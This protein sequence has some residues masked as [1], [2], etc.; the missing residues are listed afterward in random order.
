MIQV[1][2]R[3]GTRWNVRD[4]ERQWCPRC[5][6]AL[7][8]AQASEQW[9]TLSA[10]PRP[11]QP[12]SHPR[13]GGRLA[14]GYRW[15]AVR[16]GAG[17]PPRR[18]RLPLGPTPR[19]P[20]IPRWGLVD[21]A[22][23]I[24]PEAAPP[25][26]G[27]SLRAIRATL[28]TTVV[29]LGLA[30]LLHIARYAVLIINRQVLLNSVVAGLATWLPVAASVGAMFAIVGWAFV[31]TEWL[32]SRRASAFGHRNAADPRPVWAL[33]AGCLVPLANVVWA[34]TYLVE[35]ATVE[36][37]YP[38]LRRLIWAWSLLFA[39]STLV[40]VYATATSFPSDTQGIA[41]NTVSFV[42]AYL[43]AMAATVVT[44][45]L[46]FAFEGRPVERPAHR[47]V[48]VADEKESRPDSPPAVEPE[49]Q[50]P[51]A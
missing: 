51:A 5:H 21:P 34:P 22:T 24:S 31:L 40:S 35:L 39:L 14:A 36:D 15:I 3:C 25:R 20:F 37:R 50:E 48:V 41:N 29:A 42:V 38:Y 23:R 6:G 27:P 46:V 13:S 47:W 30:A 9:I 8:S 19:Y 2:S 18:R 33:R 1:C 10:A 17:P 26:R 28:I 4:R 43:M 45:R 49:G 12:P 32:I 7:L 44:A 16:P 11:P